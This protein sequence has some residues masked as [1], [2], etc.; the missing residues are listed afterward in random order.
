MQMWHVCTLK[1]LAGG[2]I[3]LCQTL[4]GLHLTRCLRTLRARLQNSHLRWPRAARAKGLVRA[5]SGPLPRSGSRRPTGAA[6]FNEILLNVKMGRNVGQ[7][8]LEKA[9]GIFLKQ[10]GLGQCNKKALS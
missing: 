5:M 2:G 10:E 3:G 8:G 1:C 7:I 4:S 9:G 6:V